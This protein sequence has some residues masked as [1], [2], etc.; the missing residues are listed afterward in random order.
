VREAP[1]PPT[2]STHTGGGILGAGGGRQ[3]HR[4]WVIGLALLA[5]CAGGEG[6]NEMVWVRDDG[7]PAD[8][9]Q[10]Q[11]DNATCR[12]TAGY[13]TA[14]PEDVWLYTYKNCMRSLG[15]VDANERD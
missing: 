2:C 14:S 11:R 10:L 8:R 13:P 4:S 5:A 9:V 12:N 3:M 6:K 15:W 1:N 7:T